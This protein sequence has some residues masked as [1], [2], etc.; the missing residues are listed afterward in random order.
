MQLQRIFLLILLCLSGLS[1]ATSYSYTYLDNP[2][3]GTGISSETYAYDINNKGQIVGG[4]TTGSNEHHG[5]IYSSGA[6]T[7]V[8]VPNA[9]FGTSVHGINDSGQMTGLY[10]DDIS[11][12]VHSFLYDRNTFVTLDHPDAADIGFTAG[13]QAYG[14]NN[15][16]QVVG[17][18]NDSSGVGHGFLYSD[19][20]YL[21]LDAPNSIVTWAEGINDSGIVVGFFYDDNGHHGFSYDGIN[22]TVINNPNALAG[23][24]SGTIISGINNMGIMTGYIVGIGENSDQ[25]FIYDGNSFTTIDVPNSNFAQIFGIN[26][27]GH[28]VG[29]YE[30][31]NTRGGFIASPIPSPVPELSAWLPMLLGLSLMFVLAKNKRMQCM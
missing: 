5:F 26:D 25:N 31:A 2:N 15:Y 24:Y 14:I 7:S 12:R 29:R 19:G 28:I 22:Y 23:S 3:A 21:T 27:T 6:Y 4:F 11:T 20:T 16:G 9:K 30:S 13:T 10:V 17:V 18:Y 8:D 1:Q